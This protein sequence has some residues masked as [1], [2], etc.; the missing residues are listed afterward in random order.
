M[1]LLPILNNQGLTTLV[2]SDFLILRVQWL[3]AVI[4]IFISLT[5]NESEHLF[6]CI[7]HMDF[8]FYDRPVH[9]FGLTFLLSYLSPSYRFK[10][11]LRGFPGGAAVKN[12]PAKAGDTGSSPSPGKSHMPQSN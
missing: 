11:D 3:L 7:S 1:P 2:L 8:L 12:L 4:L 6:V 5:T 9:I 10:G